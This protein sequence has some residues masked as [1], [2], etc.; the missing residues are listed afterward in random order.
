M[1]HGSVPVSSARQCDAVQDSVVQYSSVMQ[2]T[3]ITATI[4]ISTQ[5]YLS[6]LHGCLQRSCCKT[7]KVFRYLGCSVYGSWIRLDQIGLVSLW[8]STHIDAFDRWELIT[9]SNIE[10]GAVCRPATR[11]RWHS[12]G[13]SVR[14]KRLKVIYSAVLTLTR[15]VVCVDPTQTHR[16]APC[17][18]SSCCRS[19]KV[20]AATSVGS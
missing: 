13:F 15:Y 17:P 9:V 18:S 12:T 19:C 2:C 10:C 7:E 1:D 3:G 5:R 4:N 8:H 14:R 16:T 11:Q 6:C 20:T